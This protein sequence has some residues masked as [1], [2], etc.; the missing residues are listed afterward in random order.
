VGAPS[1]APVG[2]VDPLVGTLIAERYHVVRLLGRG[3]MGRVYEA[4]HVGIG[5]SV[6]IKVLAPGGS[7]VIGDKK[8]FEREAFATGR[9]E[10][11]NCVVVSDFGALADG[12]L[13]LA[14][15]LLRG[16]ALDKLLEREGRLPAPRALH[17]LRHVLRGLDHAHGRGVVHRDLTTRNV[18]VIDHLGDRDFAKVLD[19][20]L[21][22]LIGSAADSGGGKLTAAGVTFGTPRYMSPEQILGKPVDHRTD[23]YA[24]SVILFELITGRLPFVAEDMQQVLMKHVTNPP[25]RIREVAPEVDVP[26][27]VEMLI[28]RGLAKEPHERPPS[29][30]AYLADVEALLAGPSTSPAA[31]RPAS[32]RAN[33]EDATV[34]LTPPR[35]P[36]P[37]PRAATPVPRPRR[38]VWPWVAGLGAVAA[39]AII[40]VIAAGHGGGDQA[41]PPGSALAAALN[42]DAGAPAAPAAGATDAGAAAPPAAAEPDAGMAAMPTE[43]IPELADIDE[44]I[45]AGRRGD[46]ERALMKLIKKYPRSAGVNYRL[47]YF[48]HYRPWPEKAMR[49]YAEAARLDRAYRSNE[50]LI[51][52][53]I[54][55]LTSGSA[56]WEAQQLLLQLMPESIPLL[57]QAAASHRSP[58]VRARAK[59]LL[60]QAPR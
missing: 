24:A 50:T 7:P 47:G 33:G 19:F 3:G 21:A 1:D 5:K 12:T 42:R 26:V 13:F 53:A 6:A 51:N 15:E 46:A 22:K 34:P 16:E 27:E 20:G 29:A 54:D 32:P 52:H 39:I 14:M 57:Q 48:Y 36:M 55:T 18:Y 10:H 30:A 60:K 56:G 11:P 43:D 37:E 35:L 23:L 38:R 28:R 8:R 31:S 40:A 25:P 17:I 59:Q 2:E 44:L 58:V 41:P 45:K 49:Y 9:L 4:V